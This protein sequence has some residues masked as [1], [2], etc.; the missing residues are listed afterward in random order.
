VHMN[1]LIRLESASSSGPV[2]HCPVFSAAKTPGCGC[3][4]VRTASHLVRWDWAPPTLVRDRMHIHS[5]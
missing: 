5:L 2:I 3:V 1:A 4:E